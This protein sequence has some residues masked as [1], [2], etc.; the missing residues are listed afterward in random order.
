MRLRALAA[1]AALIAATAASPAA[2]QN[3][4]AAENARPGTTD[5]DF[6]PTPGGVVE[7]YSSETSAPP[8]GTFHLHVK[9]GNRPGDRYRVNVY[10]LG[11]YGGSGGRLVGCL[12]SCATDKPYTAQ[13]A[14]PAP[15]AKT[16]IVRA[17]WSVTD[18][19]HVPKDWVTGYYLA[20]LRVTA[21]PDAGAAGRVRLVVRGAP[22]NRSAILVQVPVNTWQ[23]YNPWGGKSLYTSNS[24]G[25]V[26]AKTV[27]FDRPYSED[28]A[29]PVP[30]GLELQAMRF[31]E[32]N[33]YDLSYVTDVDVD[34]TPGIVMNHRL[35][36]SIGHDEYW[37]VR[38]YDAFKRGLA[39]STNIASFGANTTYWDIAY[40]SRRR[41]IGRIDLF[42]AR[43]I[44]RPECAL[45]GVQYAFNAQ[46]PASSP[47]SPYTVAAPASDTWLR[48]T[49]LTPGDQ[50]PGIVGYEWDTLNRGC[51]PGRITRILHATPKGEDSKVHP[52]DAVRGV[53]RSGARMFAAGSLQFS[54]ALDTYGG[55][56]ASPGMQL[57]MENAFDDMI[58]PAPPRPVRVTRA[59]KRVDIHAGNGV[60]PRVRKISIYAHVGSKVTLVC[61]SRGGRCHDKLRKQAVRYEARAIDRWGR[62]APAWSRT[63]SPHH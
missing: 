25:N 16:G 42:R 28:V 56:T 41:T 1:G 13:P 35:A 37:G 62:S 3:P 47:A 50:T 40:G 12:P 31:L 55:H 22:A 9:A 8:G 7:G 21:G 14:A 34:R 44:K 2:A 45:W 6:T 4:V 10:R 15:N 63:L 58:R 26:A 5:W 52:A 46:R 23:A 57:L 49:G 32:R 51:F 59:R 29:V 53:A 30:F 36:M 20:E 38:Q 11:W 18:V 54:W 48:G 61:S 39:R 60:D 19:L 17:G 43:R 27:S 33:G 24:T